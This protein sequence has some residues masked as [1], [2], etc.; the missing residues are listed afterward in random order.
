MTT[1]IRRA[2]TNASPGPRTWTVPVGIGAIRMSR[3]SLQNQKPTAVPSATAITTLTSLLRSSARW[4]TSVISA[5]G[6]VR[7]ADW[8][9]ARTGVD[10]AAPGRRRLRPRSG[11]GVRGARR[12]ASAARSAGRGSPGQAA[13]ASG[14]EQSHPPRR[15]QPPD[16]RRQ[17]PGMTGAGGAVTSGVATGAATAA[18]AAPG[19]P[20]QPA[21]GSSTP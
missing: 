8:R 5:A 4:S 2:M 6:P 20:V 21:R 13:A 16:R 10:V 1:E 12:R 9:R 17:A 7:Q 15:L 11:S 18:G 14:A 3:M 19:A